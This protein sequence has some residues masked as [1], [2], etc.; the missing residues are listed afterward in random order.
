MIFETTRDGAL[1]KLDDFI[2]NEIINYNSKRN[3]DFGPKERKNVS[4]LFDII[5]LSTCIKNF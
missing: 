3:F 4:C 5:Y 1:K 2:E